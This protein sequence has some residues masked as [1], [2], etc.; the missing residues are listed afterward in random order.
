MTTIT[1]N[2]NSLQFYNTL[3]LKARGLGL[4]F[5]LFI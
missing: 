1:N 5:P 2:N 3:V 4:I